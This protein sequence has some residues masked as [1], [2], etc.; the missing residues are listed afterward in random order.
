MSKLRLQSHALSARNPLAA[1]TL[2]QI[3][4]SLVTTKKEGCPSPGNRGGW[5]PKVLGD[6]DHPL[7][8][9]FSHPAEYRPP[10]SEFKGS[11]SIG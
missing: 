1:R 8:A 10:L 3:V 4:L 11:E 2:E 9:A 7:A 5:G 6:L